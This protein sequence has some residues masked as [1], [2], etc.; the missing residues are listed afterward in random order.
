MHLPYVLLCIV[1][2]KVVEWDD[3]TGS[4][5][6]KTSGHFAEMNRFYDV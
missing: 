2:P 4:V 6:A 1:R 5:R 3:I